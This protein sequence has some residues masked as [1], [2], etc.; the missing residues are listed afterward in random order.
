[1]GGRGKPSPVDAIIKSMMFSDYAPHA[2]PADGW[3][4]WP[5]EATAAIEATSTLQELRR[6]WRRLERKGEVDMQGG[7]EWRHAASHLAWRLMIGATTLVQVTPDMARHW[8][9]L[10]Q[11][12][13]AMTAHDEGVA[14]RYAVWMRN[15]ITD[16]PTVTC[17]WPAGGNRPVM[18]TAYTYLL[19]DGRPQLEAVVRARE[20][21][22]LLIFVQPA[23]E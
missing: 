5:P 22:P 15:G 19:G 18:F 14:A 13:A 21:M 23:T 2:C 10:Q 3:P 8:L 4:S 11:Y 20:T 16:D 17:K 12:P 7:A 6:V 9:E 1:M